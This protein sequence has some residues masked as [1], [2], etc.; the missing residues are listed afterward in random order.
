[1]AWSKGRPFRLQQGTVKQ[2]REPVSVARGLTPCRLPGTYSCR[3]SAQCRRMSSTTSSGKLT[4]RATASTSTY[5]SL[6]QPSDEN[7]TKQ[8]RSAMDPRVST[9]DASNSSRMSSCE[10]ASSAAVLLRAASPERAREC[11]AGRR[12]P[13]G[14]SGQ[15]W[16]GGRAGK[17][18]ERGSRSGRAGGRGQRWEGARVRR[19]AA[20]RQ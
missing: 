1:M 9:L 16:A 13:T 8:A 20:K 6:V 7:P 14:R 2:A 18:R 19:R 11:L 17:R 10:P 5:K 12:T 3:R 15:L 4:A